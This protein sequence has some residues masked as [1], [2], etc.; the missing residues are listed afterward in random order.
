MSKK[1]NREQVKYYIEVK[2]NSGCL[3]LSEFYE[4]NK[5][6]LQIQC[7]CTKPFNKTFDKFKNKKEQQ[8]PDCGRKIQNA[9]H[10]K[11]T[12]KFKQELFDKYNDEFILTGEYTKYKLPVTI[13]HNIESCGFENDITPDYI[14]NNNFTCPHCKEKKCNLMIDLINK[15][16]KSIISN[17]FNELI[18]YPVVLNENI[19]GI[20]II[21]NKIN[22]KYYV[23]S[24]KNIYK[25]WNSHISSLKR[26][27]H[28]NKHLQS[29]FNKYG[30]DSFS[31]F[32][33]EKCEL[34][35]LLLKEEYWINKLQSHIYGYNI[36]QNPLRPLLG[37]KLSE[38]TKHKLSISKIGNKNPMYGRKVSQKQKEKMSLLGKQSKKK[39][40]Q[41]SEDGIFVKMWDSG[42]E[43]SI[44][45]NIGTS[46]ISQCCNNKIKTYKGFIW[47]L[48]G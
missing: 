4:N 13:K 35:S 39:V 45:L 9:L 2:S 31:M 38:E 21:I 17:L 19:S 24:S 26:R 27:E 42:V 16:F 37:K 20:Y 3:L 8:C 14:L 40:Y 7:K 15:E 29:A 5:Q 6:T 12:E 48:T 30:E 46:G 47:K 36:Q 41:Y 25:R 1:Y 34:N 43:A 11:S 44:A 33:I 23:G 18:L 28:G 10:T 22:C 32:L